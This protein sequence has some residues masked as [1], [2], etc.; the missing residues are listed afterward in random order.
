MKRRQFLSVTAGIT[1]L[2]A[3]CR[4]ES[5]SVTGSTPSAT[6]TETQTDKT[7][8]LTTTEPEL[9]EL[10]ATPP[11]ET[12]DCGAAPHPVTVANSTSL[13]EQSNGFR[14][15]ASKETVTVDDEISFTL[16]NDTDQPG[17]I[18]EMYKYNILRQG[19]G[20]EPVFYTPRQPAYTDL[21]IEVV[22]DGGYRWPFTVNQRGMERRNGHNAAYHVCSP[23]EPGVYRFVFFGLGDTPVGAKFTVE[24]S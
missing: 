1:A 18:G 9:L 11:D 5:D 8:P 16:I 19:D 17:A 12:I 7:E 2:T 24:S 13:P 15:E 14:L 23:I 10:P 22:P 4:S 3:G 21:A 20:W 6:D